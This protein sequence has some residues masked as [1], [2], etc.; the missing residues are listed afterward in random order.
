PETGRYAGVVPADAILAQ[1]AT[2]RSGS[3]ESVTLQAAEAREQQS[4]QAQAAV[5]TAY[6]QLAD[7]ADAEGTRAQD[8]PGRDD[9]DTSDAGRDDPAVVQELGPGGA[10][11]VQP[12]RPHEAAQDGTTGDAVPAPEADQPTTIR[13]VTTSAGEPVQEPV[14]QES[15]GTGEHPAEQPAARGGASTGSGAY[16]QPRSLPNDPVERG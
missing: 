1:V 15:S 11:A 9:A 8:E 7:D 3:P 5:T 2:Q 16:S 6:A 14:P 13:G 12:G 10:T 4:A